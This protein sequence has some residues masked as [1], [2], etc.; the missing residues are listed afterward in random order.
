MIIANENPNDPIENVLK[1]AQEKVETT[2][3]ELVRWALMIFISHHPSARSGQLRIPPLTKRAPHNSV[4]KQQL[5]ILAPGPAI[6]GGGGLTAATGQQQ[7]QESLIQ[8]I[9]EAELVINFWR[10]DPNFNEHHE[11]WHI[12][13]PGNGVPDPSNPRNLIQKDRQGELFIYMH[14]QMLAR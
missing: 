12:V 10:E 11:H 1:V 9:N 13:Y 5:N 8:N 4:P 7:Q 14:R 2:D 6:L 3:P